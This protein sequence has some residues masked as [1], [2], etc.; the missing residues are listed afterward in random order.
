MTSSSFQVIDAKSYFNIMVK[1]QYEQFL[2]QNSCVKSA[3]LSTMLTYHM[4]E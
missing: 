3:L 4:Y 2:A 1:P